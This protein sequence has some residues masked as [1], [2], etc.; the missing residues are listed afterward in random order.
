L[1]RRLRTVRAWFASQHDARAQLIFLI[2]AAVAVIAGAAAALEWQ[3][4]A[5]WGV[6]IAIG[7]FAG[8]TASLLSRRAAL[9]ASLAASSLV[10]VVAFFVAWVVVAGPALS[11]LAACLAGAS[12]FALTLLAYRRFVHATTGA[13]D[14][15]GSFSGS[16]N[17]RDEDLRKG[18][19]RATV[20]VSTTDQDDDDLALRGL[21]VGGVAVDLFGKRRAGETIADLR[22]GTAPAHRFEL[23]RGKVSIHGDLLI[24]DLEGSPFGSYVFTGQ[25]RRD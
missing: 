25:R 10:G 21:V 16:F 14:L 4:S 11:Q 6:A 8:L 20:R 2:N 18:G 22:I 17:E 15:E 24:V 9:L 13:G 19:G 3:L 23:V 12:G 1:G 7:A 5:G